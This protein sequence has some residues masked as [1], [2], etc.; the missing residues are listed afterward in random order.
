MNPYAPFG[1]VD[2]DVKAYFRTVDQKLKESQ[3]M[4]G[5]GHISGKEESGSSEGQFLDK[6]ILLDQLMFNVV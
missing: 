6:R 5:A 3:D 1:Y 2:P 4:R